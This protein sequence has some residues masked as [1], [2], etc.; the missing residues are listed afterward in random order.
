MDKGKEDFCQ[1]C[2]QQ[3]DTVL[4]GICEKCEPVWLQQIGVLSKQLDE[5]SSLSYLF[6]QAAN[7][8][9]ETIKNSKTN[10]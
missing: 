6:E 8:A 3:N 2:E 5:K 4:D 9:K 1:L 7:A 10:S